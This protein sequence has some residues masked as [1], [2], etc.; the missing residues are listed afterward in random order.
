MKRIDERI[1][2]YLIEEANDKVN[3][4]EK[5][6]EFIMKLNVNKLPNE[7]AAELSG[8]LDMILGV[9]EDGPDISFRIS[10]AKLK[11]LARKYRRTSM[12]KKLDRK[13]SKVAVE[14]EG[15]EE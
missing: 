13:A 8:I 5:L 10:K 2:K 14:D 11:M 3:L 4:V 1:D 9:S 12:G 7:Q 6:I 15:W